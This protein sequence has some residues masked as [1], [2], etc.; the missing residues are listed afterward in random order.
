MFEHGPPAWIVYNGERFYRNRKGYYQNQ[1]GRLLHRIVWADVHGTAAPAG[2]HVHHLDGDKVNNHPANLAVVAPGEHAHS[3]NLAHP[4]GFV[5]GDGEARRAG[6]DAMW[7]TR[8]PVG[9]ICQLCGANYESRSTYSRWCSKL[10][11]GRARR[12]PD[13][14]GGGIAAADR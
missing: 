3:H 10:C 11:Q 9:R 12:R 13:L 6:V 2:W 8:Q 5:L 14:R 7:A 1:L 4:R